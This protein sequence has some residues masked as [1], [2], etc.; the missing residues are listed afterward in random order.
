MMDVIRKFKNADN[1]ATV[2][3]STPTLPQSLPPVSVERSLSRKNESRALESGRY[4]PP[5]AAHQPSVGQK[6]VEELQS[7][8]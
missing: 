8:T 3:P 1:G 4:G 6:G 2:S 5:D 7:D